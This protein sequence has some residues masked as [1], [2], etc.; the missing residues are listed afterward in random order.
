[1]ETGSGGYSAAHWQHNTS[2]KGVMDP[3]FGNGEWAGLSRYDISALK[4]VGWAPVATTASVP[5]LDYVNF[6]GTS[7]M[8]YGYLLFDDSSSQV[9][10]FNSNSTYQS[11]PTSTLAANNYRGFSCDVPQALRDGAEAIHVQVSNDGGSTYSNS[12][13]VRAAVE[14]TGTTGSTGST[15]TTGS[16]GSTGTTGSTGS[17]GTTGTTELPYPE[18][19]DQ[20]E[21]QVTPALVTLSSQQSRELSSAWTNRGSHTWEVESVDCSG[22]CQDPM[23]SPSIG[24]D[25]APGQ[26]LNVTVSFPQT[27]VGTY[28][29]RTTVTLQRLNRRQST[30]LI[31]NFDYVV[32]VTSSSLKIAT[33]STLTLERNVTLGVLSHQVL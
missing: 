31:L 16:T 17:T 24:E 6:T 23:S 2:K 32:L 30:T 27:S 33:R 10:Q 12:M 28:N 1:L 26:T 22:R 21:T 18:Q 25:I 29:V 3:S 4:C 14:T 15:G 8:V 11:A 19:W 20:E 5:T 13:L 7:V 9:C